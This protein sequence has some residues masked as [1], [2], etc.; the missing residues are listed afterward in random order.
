M[1]VEIEEKVGVR[2]GNFLF[3]QDGVWSV[4]DV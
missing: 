4:G 3:R 1:W 2:A